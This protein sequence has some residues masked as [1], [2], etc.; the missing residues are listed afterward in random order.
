MVKFIRTLPR[1][2]KWQFRRRKEASG[3]HVEALLWELLADGVGKRYTRGKNFD[4][5]VAYIESGAT[6]LVARH[7]KAKTKVSFLHVDYVWTGLNPAQDKPFY[8]EMD[9]I[10][11]VSGDV[12]RS[13]I[14]E[15]P[16]LAPKTHLF[17]NMVP[18]DEIRQKAR[19]G[20]G[21]T[22]D[23]DGLR[24]VTVAR[25]HSQKALE[26]AIP[27]FALALKSG[28]NMKWY[29]LGEGP[30]RGYLERLISEYELQDKFIL[31]GQKENPY[32]YLAQS[33]IFV[34]ASWFEGWSIAIAEALI[35]A[36]PIIA[37][38]CTGTRE[39]IKNGETGLLITLSIESLADAIVKLAR[40]HKLR[41]A[42]SAA[43]FNIDFTETDQI[44]LLYDLADGK[45][46][47]PYR[48]EE[49]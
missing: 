49:V 28:I 15:L 35:L 45:K 37:T 26:L 13:L 10:F 2:L 38:D 43:L 41:E 42:F 21:F 5:A 31:M 3:V 22:D 17:H 8:D 1:N 19:E 24:L 12:R 32:P 27:A 4:L 47:A 16:E 30:E 23:F 20:A 33:D 46:L 34:Q 25:L 14:K 6:Y 44:D 7:I 40:D 48:D 39:Q 11:C 18:A 9:T 29:V 36:R